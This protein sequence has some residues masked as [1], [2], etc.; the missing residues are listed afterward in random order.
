MGD[1]DGGKFGRVRQA[2][3]KSPSLVA[4]PFLPNCLPFTEGRFSDEHDAGEGSERPIG[5]DDRPRHRNGL[6]PQVADHQQRQKPKPHLFH[7]FSPASCQDSHHTFA[8]KKSA[9]SNF[10]DMQLAGLSGITPTAPN[11]PFAVG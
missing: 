9:P 2:Q 3:L 5:T 8:G 1:D 6:R 11:E 7:R 10:E 4:T